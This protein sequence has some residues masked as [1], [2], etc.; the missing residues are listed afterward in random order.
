MGVGV[1]VSSGTFVSCGAESAEDGG[2]SIGAERVGTA[3]PGASSTG[4]LGGE[5]AEPVP[6]A[7]EEEWEV[8]PFIIV[9]RF[10]VKAG[11]SVLMSGVATGALESKQLAKCRHMRLEAT[12]Q[13][14]QQVS[15]SISYA[16]LFGATSGAEAPVGEGGS[17]GLSSFIT[18]G[19]SGG[20]VAMREVCDEF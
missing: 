1:A 12:S 3:A 19:A 7:I 10:S 15:Q 6:L 14:R 13:T 11:P 4:D 2:V 17:R 8:L 20:G 18:G 5:A 9:V 16:Y